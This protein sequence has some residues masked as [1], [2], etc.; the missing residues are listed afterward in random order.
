MDLHTRYR[1]RF[2][3]FRSGFVSFQLGQQ[4]MLPALA[5]LERRTGEAIARHQAL[6]RRV[7]GIKDGKIRAEILDWVGDGSLPGSPSDRFRHVK[8]E[9]DQA[10][11]WD[12]IRTGHLDDLE[13]V[14]SELETRVVNG[15]K[16]GVIGK[17]GPMAILDDHGRL[18]GVGA[19]LVV[20]AGA[21]LFVVTFIFK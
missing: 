14:N 16:S 20:V 12:E 1:P 19:A 3:P 6:L 8:D 9:S 13:T 11:P 21:A 7:P 10:A 18:T 2:D 17:P 4:S 15:E 5:D